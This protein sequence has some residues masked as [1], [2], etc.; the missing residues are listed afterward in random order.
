MIYEPNQH[1]F[2]D[3]PNLV[4]YRVVDIEV[5]IVLSEIVINNIKYTGKLD[6]LAC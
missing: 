1:N 6:S 5:H 2:P 4:W 3:H